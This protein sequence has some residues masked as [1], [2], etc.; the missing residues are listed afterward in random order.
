MEDDERALEIARINAKRRD[1]EGLDM[2]PHPGNRLE[3]E[4]RYDSPGLCGEKAFAYSGGG[5]RG[6]LD[7]S[8]EKQMQVDEGRKEAG[9]GNDEEAKT[10]SSGGYQV[11]KYQPTQ[12]SVTEYKSI[13]DAP[14]SS[15]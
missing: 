4:P 2:R 14:D 10:S 9:S 11:G 13:Y 3:A 7:A 1:V 15:K 5:A 6:A 8:L 12:Y